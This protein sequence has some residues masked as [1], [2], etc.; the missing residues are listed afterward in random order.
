MLGYVC[1]NKVTEQIKI[2]EIFFSR[3]EEFMNWVDKLELKNEG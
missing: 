2:F 1:P 3:V